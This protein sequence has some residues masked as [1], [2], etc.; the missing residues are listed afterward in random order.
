MTTKERLCGVP[1]RG[2]IVQ[3]SKRIHHRLEWKISIYSLCH[4]SNKHSCGGFMSTNKLH[5]ESTQNQYCQLVVK[6]CK[7]IFL[8]ICWIP[9]GNRNMFQNNCI[10][11][12]PQLDQHKCK[13]TQ[14]QRDDSRHCWNGKN[15]KTAPTSRALNSPGRSW[16]HWVDGTVPPPSR[17]PPSFSS[18]A[19][20]PGLGTSPARAPLVS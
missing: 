10:T 1:Q 4:L 3:L 16:A 13:I 12:F 2:F 8:P 7:G 14:K 9:C 19:P 6:E 15:C 5:E 11:Y 17:L 20:P 18:S